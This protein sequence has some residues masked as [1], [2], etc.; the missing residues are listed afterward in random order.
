MTQPGSPPQPARNWRTWL[1]SDPRPGLQLARAAVLGT[2]GSL[3]FQQLGL[4]LAWLTG[5]LIASTLANLSGVPVSIPDR[6]RGLLMTMLGISMGLGLHADTFAA[7]GHWPLS[8]VLLLVNI[9]L[10]MAAGSW[11]L[12]LGFRWDRSTALMASLPGVLSYVLAVIDST[13]AEPRQVAIAQSLRV[14]LLVVLLPPLLLDHGDAG[15]LPATAH[16]AADYPA[17]AL[18]LGLALGAGWLFERL[19]VPAGYLSAGLLLAGAAKIGGLV[20]GG[21]PILVLLVLNISFG[22]FVGS[23]FLGAGWHDLLRLLPPSLCAVGAMTVTSLLTALATATLTD[24]PLPA[25]L[26]AFVPGGLE[27][28]V[29]IAF[30]MGIEPVYVAAHHL[31]RFVALAVMVPAVVRWLRL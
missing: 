19:R 7:L 23:R 5:A 18:M 28:M 8:A 10:V 21:L 31:L 14:F 15:A 13:R 4:P 27:A 26:L 9:G 30:M 3:T 2:M 6:L 17:L 1:L 24:L 20:T 25:V 12:R 22:C 16:G 29:L 11:L